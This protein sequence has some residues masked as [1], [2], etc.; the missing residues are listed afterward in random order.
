[1][2]GQGLQEH[3]QK[4]PPL[5]EQLGFQPRISTRGSKESKF[6]KIFKEKPEKTQ[7]KSLNGES[8]ARGTDSYRKGRTEGQWRTKATLNRQRNTADGAQDRVGE[9]AP[10]LELRSG[11]DIALISLSFR[12]WLRV[13]RFAPPPSSR[14]SG[15]TEEEG[16]RRRKRGKWQRNRNGCR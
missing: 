8:N 4:Q 13:I 7:K 12:T 6:E 15:R 11:I 16:K 9:A 14:F 10:N 3:E 5:Y 2:I 1:M